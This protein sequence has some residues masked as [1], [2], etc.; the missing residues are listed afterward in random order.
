MDN[1]ESLEKRPFA[2]EAGI[3]QDLACLTRNERQKLYAGILKEKSSPM[4]PGQVQEELECRGM[5]FAYVGQ[6]MAAMRLMPFVSIEGRG[7]YQWNTIYKG[8]WTDHFARHAEKSGSRKRERVEPPLLEVQHDT[9]QS[10]RRIPLEASERFL[11]EQRAVFSHVGSIDRM[12]EKD[13]GLH[14]LELLLAISE[15]RVDQC[16]QLAEVCGFRD[17]RV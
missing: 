2:V 8:D 9:L 12:K 17:R 7:M 10:D 13:Q 16:Q 4:T 5:T 14:E 15:E 3:F 11:V 1:Q 6:D